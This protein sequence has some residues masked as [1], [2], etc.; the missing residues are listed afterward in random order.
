MPA[1]HAPSARWPWQRSL[2]SRIIFA[3]GG[4]FL[5]VLALLLA[6]VVR[7]VYATQLSDAEHNLEIEAFLA[8]NALEDPLSGYEAEFAEYA[9]WESEQD[10]EDASDD[11]KDDG[12][13]DEN[14][15]QQPTPT[16]S[17]S[18]VSSSAPIATRLQAVANL[19]ASD[20]GARVTI[21]D[22]QG[23]VVADSAYI[24]G[25]VDNQLGQIEVQAALRG[26]EQHDIRRDPMSGQQSLYAAAPIQQ[27]NQVLG[28]VQISR[29]VQEVTAS[30]WSLIFGIVAAGFL[31]LAVATALGVWISR[32]LVQPVRA[33][34]AASLAIAQG[35][36]SQQV[37]V[38]SAD[39]LG[40]LGRAFNRMVEELQRMIEQQRL[41]IANASHELRTPLTNIKLRSEALLD[42]GLDDPTIA[43]RY[44]GDIDSEADRLARL[45]N[46]L[47]DLSRLERGTGAPP[48]EAVDIAPVLLAVARSARLGVHAAGLSLRADIPTQ[49]PP[50]R[51]WPEQVEAALVNLLD[52]AVKYTPKGGEVRLSVQVVDGNCQILVADTGLG[53]P[54]EDIPHI[55]ER[56]YRVDK[57]RSRRSGSNSSGGA[58]LGLAIVKVLA[59]QNGG[60]IRAESVVGAG[61]TF[62]LE[63]PFSQS[64]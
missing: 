35:D 38:T 12:K 40:A 50:L 57:A 32:R 18:N 3:Y 54:A 55:F 41:F 62:I 11:V 23:D 52:N 47:L 33:L 21:L 14:A 17:T 59:E 64:A 29:P 39:E 30:I 13:D 60:R 2:Q 37:P 36:L 42:G 51:V 26:E 58:G 10:S 16:S 8:A 15:P 49:L 9:R 44:L 34:E 45:A 56:F 24:F 27:G 19:Y 20:T 4:V 25:Q 1:P 22:V 63:F 46:T 31:A 5:I 28:V 6:V 61:T 48:T 7:V 43:R 53:I